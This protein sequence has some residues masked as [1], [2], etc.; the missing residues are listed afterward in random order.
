MQS[1]DGRDMSV[2]CGL[3]SLAG[4]TWL[5][6]TRSGA[7]AVLT[8]VTEHPRPKV[9]EQGRPLL[10]RG[11][12]VMAWMEAHQG[13]SSVNTRSVLAQ[14]HGTRQRYAGF[15]LLLGN[16]QGTQAHMVYV[17]NRVKATE[18]DLLSSAE[19]RPVCGMS[20]ST[21]HSPWPKIGRGTALIQR[22]LSEPRT[23]TNELIERLFGVLR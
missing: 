12:L 22:I 3:D 2:L 15:N 20:N 13:A 5:G 18:P 7:F 9:D 17:S 6:V 11:E 21:L 4:G 10:S 19:A 1:R 8:N 23:S 16:V 14:L